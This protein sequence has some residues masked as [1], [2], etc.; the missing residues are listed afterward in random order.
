MEK[1]Y[2][3]IRTVNESKDPSMLGYLIGTTDR[4]IDGTYQTDNF[5]IHSDYREVF[6]R[7]RDAKKAL[8]MTA[9]IKVKGEDVSHLITVDASVVALFDNHHLYQ[10]V[11]K[12]AHEIG[13]SHDI[14]ICPVRD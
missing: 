2:L 5:Q 10:H 7:V 14:N 11:L 9:T 13:D 6:D 8:H 12:I 1:P 4:V 3:T